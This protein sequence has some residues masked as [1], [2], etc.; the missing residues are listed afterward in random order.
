MAM[1]APL[2]ELYFV[3]LYRQVASVEET[4]PSKTY[5]ELLHKLFTKEFVWLIP[6]DDNRLEDGRDLRIEFINEQGIRDVDETWLR[7]GCSMLELF[8]GLSRRLSFEA[9]GEP[10][11]WFWHLIEN[12][13]LEEYNDN[14]R[15]SEQHIEKVLDQVIWRTYKRN[16]HG[17][18]FPLK[19]ARRDQR[20]IELWY[21]LSAYV[22]E[23]AS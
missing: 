14:W 20:D 15:L 11:T 10:Q 13:G 4:N 17:G 22:L 8:V 9:D 12:L 3:W 5:W 21:Q 19:R 1:N 16:G 7:L 6:N 2:D 18:L 23:R